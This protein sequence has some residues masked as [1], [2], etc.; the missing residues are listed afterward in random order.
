MLN[1]SGWTLLFSVLVIFVVCRRF[2]RNFGRQ[3]FRV[4]RL[5]F[6]VL[7]FGALTLFLAAIALGS[8]WMVPGGA[9]NGIALALVAIR[10]TTFEHTPAQSFYRP[11]SFIGLAVFSLF[12]GRLLLRLP[13]LISFLRERPWEN[14]DPATSG[15]QLDR[16]DGVPLTLAILFLLVTYYTV[17]YMGI[18]L[19]GWSGRQS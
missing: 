11:N 5:L 19:R 16:D 9:V 13:L 12:L 1:E 10:L 3:R 7:L 17:Y 14:W 15:V 4:A 2:K 18:L 6:R 8:N